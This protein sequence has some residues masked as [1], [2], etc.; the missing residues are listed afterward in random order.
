MQVKE[1]PYACR[2]ARIWLLSIL[3]AIC[4]K[5]RFTYQIFLRLRIARVIQKARIFIR[6]TSIKSK[7]KAWR[8][9]TLPSSCSANR[10]RTGGEGEK[11]LLPQWLET[12]VKSMWLPSLVAISSGWNG[13]RVEEEEEEE[14]ALLFG[15]EKKE[16]CLDFHRMACRLSDSLLENVSRG[17]S[18]AGAFAVDS[19]QTAW[20]RRRLNPGQR[21][22][23]M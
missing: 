20:Q 1:C 22:V 13:A 3:L 10:T 16:K 23:F 19:T 14:G 7:K 12:T 2:A 18:H 5:E 21:A 8:W 17:L 6:S 11:R 9:H 15:D 4:T